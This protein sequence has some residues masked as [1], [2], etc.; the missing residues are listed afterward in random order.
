MEKL[1]LHESGT[2]VADEAAEGVF[3]IRIITEG[4][5]SS[6]IYS[7]EML[8]ENAK[9]FRSGT[10]SFIDHPKDPSKPWERSLTSLVGKLNEEAHYA[11][12]DEGVAG[13]Y[14]SLKVTKPGLR[15]WVRENLDV[16]ELSI[17]SDAEGE[18]NS[19]GKIVVERFVEDDPY[20]SVDLVVAAGRGG[21]FERAMESLHA[22]ENSTAEVE[23]GSAPADRTTT[24]KEN[25]DM[26]LAELAEKVDKLT[27]ALE[28]FVGSATPILE[29][30]KPAEVTEPITDEA[31][32]AIAESGLPKTARKVVLEAVRNGAVAEDA[33]KDQKDFIEGLRQELRVAE[34][35]VSLNESVTGDA[36]ELGKVLD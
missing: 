1:K 20:R 15:E 16:I 19:D 13:L 11:V 22:I 30:L 24:S 33:I 6:G 12:D 10:K 26:E 9:I 3:P 5:G 2:L 31:V 36:L 29:S 25:S 34:G 17:Y 8:Q 7:R 27:I 32:E 14:S 23:D 28:A 4:E 18:K 21:R 35:Y